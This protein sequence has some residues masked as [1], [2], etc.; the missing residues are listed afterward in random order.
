MCLTGTE[1]KKLRK[2]LD[3]DSNSGSEEKRDDRITRDWT[4]GSLVNSLWGLSWPIMITHLVTTLGP[5][6]DMIWVGKLGAAAVAGVGI[7]GMVVLLMNTARMGLQMGTRALIARCI[8][9]GDYEGANQVGQQTFV[10]SVIFSIAVAIIGIT[11]ARPIMILFG[12]APDVVTEGA[13]Y[14]RIQLV[15]MI[16]LSLQMMSQS[17]MQSS[18][19]AIAPMYFGVGSRIFHIILCPFLVFGW[20]I[21][22]DMGV[23]GA[24]LTG[25]ISQGIAGA[26]GLWMLYTG[27]TRLKL[28]FRNFRFDGDILWRIVKIGTP[29]MIN[30]MGRTSANLVMTFFVVPFGTSAV[31]AQA[32]MERLDRFIQM[33][34]MSLGQSAGVL[35]GQNLG[36][37]KPERAERTA[38]M[39][40]GLFTAFMAVASV[41]IFFFAPNIV[42]LFNSEPE[43][44]TITSNFLRITL[45]TYM[46]FG[47]VQVLMQCLNGVGE[48][49]F[50][51]WTTVLTMVGVMVPL[52]WILPNHTNLDVYGV[53]WAMVTGNVIRAIVFV[54][55]FRTGRWKKK[56]I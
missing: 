55:Y 3:G 16:T 44:V 8:G 29:A 21:F 6:I 35:A 19:D 26:L 14:M 48:T 54:V 45:V 42:R 41:G 12:V 1:R 33:P 38:W 11:L 28:T 43:L 52:A 4:Q 20:W 7:S 50:P 47:L 24:A 32:L 34:A 30:G 31:A 23:E 27:K 49:V 13:N 22:P 56:K 10:I 53:R 15:G 40:V 36:A 39:A 9:A 25:V 2:T 46:V 17:I 5:T 51:A 37:G 18:G